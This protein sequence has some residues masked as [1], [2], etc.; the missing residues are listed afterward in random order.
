MKS[1]MHA[2]TIPNQVTVAVGKLSHTGKSTFLPELEY[3]KS[4]LP[5][6]Q[7][8]NIKLTL[9]SPSWYHFRYG[10]KKAYL[11]GVY[12]SDDE[13]FADLAKAYQTELQILYDA[14]LRN[15]QVDD[16]NLAYFCSESM[17]EGWKNDPENFQ[18]AEQQLDAYIKFYNECFGKRP[19]DF[20]LGIHLCRGN[21]MGSKHFSEG[22][23]DRIATK[24]F[25]DLNVSTYYLEYD[26]PRAGGFE[27]LKYL[28]KDKN[29]V[30]GV[31]TSKFPELEDKA[32]M[33]G[34]VRKAAE[35][36]AQGTGRSVEEALGQL[37]VSPQCGFASH[38]EGN[39]LEM[40]DMRR[41][42]KLVRAVA[43]EIWPG[44]P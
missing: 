24:L 22:A 44:E 38:A 21:Y 14:G 17:L 27:P 11:P 35:F 5:E 41:K 15:A 10:P 42:L 26:T 30:V 18:T 2:K 37:S 40:E 7:W 3:L 25:N 34:R 33:V 9:T 4:I 36:I 32:E 8:K 19:K 23:Y 12:A 13:Y 1:F 20:H 43:D 39:Q 16:P 6:S 31:V 29:V 28:P